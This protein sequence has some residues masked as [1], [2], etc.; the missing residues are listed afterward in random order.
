M[1]KRGESVNL[2][3]KTF[4]IGWWLLFGKFDE[5]DKRRL[6]N[7]LDYIRNEGKDFIQH[8]EIG[9]DKDGVKIQYKREF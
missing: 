1:E 8:I 4:K 9:A 6:I 3:G 5:E 2:V 7:A